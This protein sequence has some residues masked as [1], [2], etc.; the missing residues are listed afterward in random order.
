MYLGSTYVSTKGS[1]IITVLARTSLGTIAVVVADVS[2]CEERN[3]DRCFG[4]L[5]QRSTHSA[6]Y[7]V[8]LTSASSNTAVHSSDYVVSKVT[9]VSSF[10]I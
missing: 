7:E 9:V 1:L 2:I 5:S 4:G 3:E 8:T 10:A 6:R